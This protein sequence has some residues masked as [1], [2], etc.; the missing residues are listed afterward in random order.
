M[1]NFMELAR[2]QAAKSSDPDTKVGIVFVDEQGDVVAAG[3]NEIPKGI[4]RKGERFERPEKYKYFEHAE[5]SAIYKAANYGVQLDDTRAY[6]NATPCIDCARALI[7]VG[8]TELIMPVNHVFVNREDY[9]AQS[10]IA[11]ALLKEA[12]IN[13][14]WLDE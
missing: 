9:K 5:R 2:E 1:K 7:S 11:L 6:C 10:K 13:V 14:L 4:E 12:G 3:F 8:I